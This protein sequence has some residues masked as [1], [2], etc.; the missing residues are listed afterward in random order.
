MFEKVF[1]EPAPYVDGVLKIPILED[2]SSQFERPE[3]PATY[4]GSLKGRS[5]LNVPSLSVEEL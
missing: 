4:K 2:L 3:K 5:N 1:Q